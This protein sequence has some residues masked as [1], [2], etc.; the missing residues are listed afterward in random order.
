MRIHCPPSNSFAILFST[1]EEK[2]KKRM[3]EKITNK[4]QNQKSTH[5]PTQSK[6][7]FVNKMEENADILQFSIKDM[8]GI[9]EIAEQKNLF[10]LVVNSIA[11]G[12]YGHELVKG[13]CGKSFV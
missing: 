8:Y 2:K 5:Q 11:P 7:K 4:K 9:Q 3:K 6:S 12:I 13:W 10:R 1:K